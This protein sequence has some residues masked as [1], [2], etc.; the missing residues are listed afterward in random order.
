MGTEQRCDATA[1]AFWRASGNVV[2]PTEPEP[3][4]EPEPEAL[5][6]PEPDA[7]APPPRQQRRCGPSFLIVGAGRSGTS[8]LYQYLLQH[9]Q[10][11]PAKQKQLQFWCVPVLQLAAQLLPGL[12]RLPPDPCMPL[13]S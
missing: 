8:S 1:R 5:P 11:V 12:S 6:L 7:G 10:V 13:P 2:W 9:P 3:E 4:P